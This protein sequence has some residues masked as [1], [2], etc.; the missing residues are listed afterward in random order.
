[1]PDRSHN[2]IRRVT[3]MQPLAVDVDQDV[4]QDAEQEVPAV[5]EL[6][7]VVLRHPAVVAHRRMAHRRM[8]HHRVAHGKPLKKR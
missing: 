5:A 8:A 3:P 2:A 1:M 4:D 7:V 6:P